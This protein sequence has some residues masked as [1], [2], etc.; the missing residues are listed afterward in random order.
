MYHLK[1]EQL[2]RGPGDRGAHAP[3]RARDGALAIAN[4]SPFLL[5][6]CAACRKF[7]AARRRNQHARRVRSPDLT[8]VYLTHISTDTGH[9][10]L[11]ATTTKAMGARVQCCAIAENGMLSNAMTRDAIETAVREG[12]P[13][14]INMA[15]EK[16]YEV[17]QEFKVAPGATRVVA[18]DDRD[19][20]HVL[21]L[22][23]M[24][25][26]SYLPNDNGSATR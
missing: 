25:G 8:R 5:E 26:I 6:S 16:S 23:T 17:R 22:L 13:F 3:P 24:T 9:L 10:E 12:I 11:R 20:P 1:R 4:F 14:V 7:V 19:L 2:P 21:P 15:D 18:L